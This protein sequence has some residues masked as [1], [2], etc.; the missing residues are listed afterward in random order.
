MGINYESFTSYHRLCNNIGRPCSVPSQRMVIFRL[1]SQDSLIMK[2]FTAEQFNKK[3]A[4][5]YRE[6]L[7]GDVAIKHDRY[8]NKVFFL[9]AEPADANSFV[10]KCFITTR[11]RNEAIDYFID[12][13]VPDRAFIVRDANIDNLSVKYTAVWVSDP[14]VSDETIWGML[15]WSYPALQRF[16]DF[17][18]QQPVV[19]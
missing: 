12:Q 14:D 3:P 6:A 8:P 16:S 2:T 15:A 18:D 1:I 13:D 7:E 17:R 10:M 9:K 5:V 11:E 19:A 4:Q